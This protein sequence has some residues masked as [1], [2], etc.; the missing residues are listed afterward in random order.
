MDGVAIVPLV[1]FVVLTILFIISSGFRELIKLLIQGL[2]ALIVGLAHSMKYLFKGVK[3]ILVYTFQSGDAI[4]QDAM[5]RDRKEEE[6]GK[7][8]RNKLRR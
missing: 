2:W 3:I 4:K 5:R 1:G 6:T 8:T 7:P